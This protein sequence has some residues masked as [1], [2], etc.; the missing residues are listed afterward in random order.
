MPGW[1]MVEGQRMPLQLVD[2]RLARPCPLRR[3]METS[4]AVA[5]R[6]GG[7][8]A[9]LAGVGEHLADAVFIVIDGDVEVAAAD[10]APF[11]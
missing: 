4:R 5:S 6:L 11:R 2:D 9:G 8:A 3:A 10:L 7:A 1:R